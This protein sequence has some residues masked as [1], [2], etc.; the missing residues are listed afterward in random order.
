VL[1]READ[2]EPAGLGWA[3]RTAPVLVERRPAWADDFGQE[4]PAELEPATGYKATLR[5]DTGALIGIVGADYEPLDNREAFRFV[6]ELIG[7]QLHFETAGSLWG[8]RRV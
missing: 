1:V 4:Q 2:E 7:S 5:S 8:G 3:V 6:D